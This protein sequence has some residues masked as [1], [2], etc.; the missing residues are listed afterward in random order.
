MF[1]ISIL[2]WRSR[3]RWLVLTTAVKSGLEAV[4]ESAHDGVIGGLG[5]CLILSLTFLFL[6]IFFIFF[7]AATSLTLGALVSVVFFRALL[8]LSMRVV[9]AARQTNPPQDYKY[10]KYSL[11]RNS[12][13][14]TKK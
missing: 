13:A 4:L 12:A 8:A 6:S 1:S 5:G 10:L 2:L 7:G 14:E 11:L 3:C 9:V